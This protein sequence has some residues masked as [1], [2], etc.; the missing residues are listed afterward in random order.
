VRGLAP[1]LLLLASAAACALVAEAGL[2]LVGARPTAARVNPHFRADADSGWAESHPVLGWRNRAGAARSVEPGHAWMHFWSDG[3]RATRPDAEQG[4][5]DGPLVLWT[6]GSFAQGYGIADEE[7]AAWRLS[8]CLP[9]ARFEN[10]ATGGYGTVQAWLSVGVAAEA[11]PRLER[12]ALVLYGMLAAHAQRNVATWDWIRSLTD[13]NGNRVEPPRAR[14]AGD[15]VEILPFR[16]LPDWPAEAHSALLTALHDLAL[17]GALHDREAGEVEATRRVLARFADDVR[18]RGAR[19]VVVLLDWANHRPASL[20]S[21]RS[22]L[23]D[24]GVDVVDCGVALEPGSPRFR[25]GGDSGHPSGLVNARW[26]ACVADWL[27]A[28]GGPAF[29]RPTEGCAARP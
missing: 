28:H 25:T 27:Q 29:A 10:V 7:T 15:G 9:G 23:A 12:P 22:A 1:A 17:R 20:A 6:G 11:S 13:R 16:T 2:R 4:R 24:D 14:L 19:P 18:A 3:R 5:A 26:S 21:Y 8:A